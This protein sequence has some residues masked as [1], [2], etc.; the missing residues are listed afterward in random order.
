MNLDGFGGLT[1]FPDVAVLEPVVGHFHLIAVD[2]LLLEQAVF[3][4]DGAAHRGQVERGQR[5]HKARRQTAQTA[6]AQTGLGLALA[7]FAQVETQFVHRVHIRLFVEQVNHVVVHGA[8]DQELGREVVDL[9]GLLPLALA[10]RGRAA[11]HHL[12]A[13]GA[14]QR[15]I[16]LFLSSIGH[17]AAEVAFQLALNRL[18]Y[19]ILIINAMRHL[20][21]SLF[22]HA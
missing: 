22:I 12:V 7:D 21:S 1:D 18:D 4:A 3:I 11:L 16:N 20:F 8:A 14:G 15:L 13:H 2:Y 10:A 17:L 6:V 19:L 9:L 5:I